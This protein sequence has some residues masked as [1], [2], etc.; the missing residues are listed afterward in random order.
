MT[1]EQFT[2]LLSYVADLTMS[3]KEI[4]ESL[5]VI[6]DEVEQAVYRAETDEE[7]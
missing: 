2:E 1:D 6:R 3:A 7:S 4:A 5:K